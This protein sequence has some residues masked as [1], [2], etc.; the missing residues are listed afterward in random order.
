[1]GD[2]GLVKLGSWRYLICNTCCNYYAYDNNYGCIPLHEHGLNI[3]GSVL[4]A[5]YVVPVI[6]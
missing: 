4:S 1:M 6:K 3:M 2:K 5:I